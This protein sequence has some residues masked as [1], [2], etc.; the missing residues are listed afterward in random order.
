MNSEEKS[1]NMEVL[2][3]FIGY[4]NP[5]AK[6]WFLG[7]EEH[8]IEKNLDKDKEQKRFE[9]YLKNYKK[10]EPFFLTNDHFTNEMQNE[11]SGNTEKSKT[12]KGIVDFYNLV[13]KNENEAPIDESNIGKSDSKIF[14]LN[15]Y[16][17]PRKTTKDA[18]NPFVKEN[19]FDGTFEEWKKIYFNNRKE[20]LKKFLKKNID[21]KKDEKNIIC[22]STANWKEFEE[23]ISELLETP[24]SKL[25][26]ET[27]E[28]ERYYGILH[29]EK[30]NF[31]CI[32]HP[33]SYSNFFNE[34]YLEWL[35]NENLTRH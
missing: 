34:S 25:K 29:Y 9:I 18:Y 26:V 8:S 1:Y 20:A 16:P 14:M 24:K 17:L 13:F 28:D 35:K 30:L 31:M 2:N 21:I 3:N 19:L 27:K 32:Y 15:L 7:I 10:K 11:D 22:L 12:Y 23:M 6:Y 5:E 4:G 33:T